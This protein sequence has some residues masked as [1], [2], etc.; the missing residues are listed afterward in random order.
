MA[1]FLVSAERMARRRYTTK[2]LGTDAEA[3]AEIAA[4]AL[5]TGRDNWRDP[6]LCRHFF[7]TC[8]EPRRVVGEP[9]AAGTE[10]GE[11]DGF[12]TGYFEPEIE[13]SPTRSRDFPVPILRRPPDLV[14]I[15]DASRP[16]DLAPHF[17]FARRTASGLE[18]YPDRAAIEAG[19]LDPLELELFWCRSRIDLFFVQIQGSARLR[20]PDGLIRRISYDGKSGHPFT[21]IGRVLIERGAIDP[22]TVS[23]QSIRAWLEAHPEEA[24]QVM[25]LNRSYIF[26]QQIDH[27]APDMGP[28]DMGPPDMG[29]PDMGPLAAAGVFLTPRRSLAVDHRLH[30]FGSPVFIATRDPLP[31]EAEPFRQLMIA[32]DTGSAIIGPARGDLFM[33]SGP[34]AGIAAGAIRHAARFTLLLPRPYQG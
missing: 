34:S 9:S 10:G 19:A 3:L 13:A 4:R 6:A 21:A 24:G 18:E 30:T 12:V 17:F 29:P 28:P 27:P 11:F 15:D 32:Q 2:A 5:D 7:E 31:G 20:L 16:S 14:E 1:A 22:A 33:G 23:M 8:F 26:F 25:Q